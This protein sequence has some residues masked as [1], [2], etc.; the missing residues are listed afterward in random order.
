MFGFSNTVSTDAAKIQELVERGVSNI[1]PSRE[2]LERTL[3]SGRRLRVYFGIDPTGTTLHLGHAVN[4]LKL[5][6]FQDLGHEVIV[7]YGGFT[8]QIG[9]PSG[10]S[11]E[12]KPLTPAQIKKNQSGYKKQ[13]GK[14]LDLGK[15]S[16]KFLDNENWTNKLKPRDMIDLASQFTI[17]QLLE[18]DLFRTRMKE[19]KE[20]YLHEFLYPVFQAY[21]A[22]TM[23]VDI[24]LGGNDQLFNI[25]AGRTLMRKLKNKEKFGLVMKLLTDSS[26]KKMGKTEGNMVE[27][28][29]PPDEMF[30]KVMSWDDTLILVGMELCT[31]I[32]RQEF[33]HIGAQ[34]ERGELNPRDAKIRLAKEIVAIYHGDAAAQ[35]AAEKFSSTFS[36]AEFP[37]DAPHVLV[38]AGTPLADA[39]AHLVGSKSE[40]VRLLGEGAVYDFKTGAKISDR[41]AVV[42]ADMD[43]RIGKHRFLRVKVS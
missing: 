9:D 18:R 25:L 24:Q 16:V 31:T 1:L 7:L 3:L 41:K 10:K 8:A 42:G 4:L 15:A 5:R 37:A 29:A 14:I 34:M 28:D 33:Q 30:G 40:F 23:D 32:P 27:L 21:D 35:K 12:R 17:A 22:V 38:S 13:I 26:G 19:G 6:A 43:L 36:R 20:I 2:L 39:V 11:S